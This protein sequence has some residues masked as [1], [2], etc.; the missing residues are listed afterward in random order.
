MRAKPSF[1]KVPTFFE[2]LLVR[3]PRPQF[4]HV[5][6]CVEK[7]TDR[8]PRGGAHSTPLCTQT[9]RWDATAASA[10]APQSAQRRVRALRDGDA[11]F[12]MSVHLSRRLVQFRD[13]LLR[14]VELLSL[15]LSLGSRRPR[16]RLF[17]SLIMSL[18]L[19]RMSG[20]HFWVPSSSGQ[21]WRW[22]A[23]FGY[24]H[25]PA[26]YASAASTGKQDII[27]S[28]TQ[29]PGYLYLQQI[30]HISMSGTNFLAIQ[31]DS[32]LP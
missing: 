25:Y 10:E 18:I 15:P 22:D 29:T 16:A 1:S 31:G 24:H 27:M 6:A 30:P 5:H 11:K 28:L 13:V 14:H 32:H 21:I 7:M 9:P 17:Q 26:K 23:I 19:I 20:C 12:S 2:F 4:P 8:A 3:L